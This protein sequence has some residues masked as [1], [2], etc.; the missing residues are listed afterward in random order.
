MQVL[1]SPTSA[2][3]VLAAQLSSVCAACFPEKSAALHFPLAV[4]ACVYSL[5]FS[6][7]ETCVFLAASVPNR[8]S[9]FATISVA[10]LS[11]ARSPA[12]SRTSWACSVP[13]PRKTKTLAIWCCPQCR[14]AE[15][16][17]AGGNF[18]SPDG[19]VTCFFPE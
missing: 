15:R 13:F 16:A 6:V 2:S 18:S 4:S 7:T 5:S 8:V 3:A 17:K 1:L 9:S 19:D 10:T 14:R 11:P 12:K